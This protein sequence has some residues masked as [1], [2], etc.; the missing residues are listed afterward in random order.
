MKYIFIYNKC[1]FVLLCVYTCVYIYMCFSVCMG[2]CVCV[3]GCVCVRV[4]SGQRGLDIPSKSNNN[5][6]KTNR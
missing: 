3:Y 2:V 1:V 4:E 5:P 6:C